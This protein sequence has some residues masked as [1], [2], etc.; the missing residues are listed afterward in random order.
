MGTLRAVIDSQDPRIL[1]IF[2]EQTGQSASGEVLEV[3]DG[4]VANRLRNRQKVIDAFVELVNEGSVA[5]IDQIVERSGV[6]RRSLFR[7]FTDLADLTME[8]FRRVVADAP[9]GVSEAELGVGPLDVRIDVFVDG[10][11]RILAST[12]PFGERARRRPDVDQEALRAGI[13]VTADIIRGRMARH[14]ERELANLSPDQAD[15]RLDAIYVMVSFESYEV[16]V[17]QIGRPIDVVRSIWRES[18]RSM[19]S[20]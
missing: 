9:P 11:L 20:I 3:S 2:D 18:I 17:H 8:G 15:R 16:L 6:A 1:A 4:R 14:F 13:A 10:R 12:Y 7:H 19:L 5:S